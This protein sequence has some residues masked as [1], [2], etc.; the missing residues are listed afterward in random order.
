MSRQAR[1][2]DYSLCVCNSRVFSLQ[3]VYTEEVKNKNRRQRFAVIFVFT[4][5]IVA[6]VYQSVRTGAFQVSEVELELMAPSSMYWS[7]RIKDLRGLMIP[8]QKKNIW[9]VR[10]NRVKT[11]LRRENWIKEIRLVRNFPNRVRIQVTPYSVVAVY[12]N[13]KGISVPL[14]E[15]SAWLPR[16]NLTHAPVA[17]VIR[18]GKLFKDSRL[19][20]KVSKILSAL[21]VDGRLSLESIDEVDIDKKNE[22][23]LSLMKDRHRIHISDQQLQIKLARIEKVLNYLDSEKISDRVIDAEFTQKVL[24]RPRKGE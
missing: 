3:V 22:V 21:P 24:V 9:S 12:V 14:A 18:T 10:L 19:K 20:I 7:E 23:W 5:L 17:P 16:A 2:F 8:F 15:N 1:D 13:S 6:A 11:I 4:L